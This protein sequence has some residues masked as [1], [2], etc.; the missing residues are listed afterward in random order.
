VGKAGRLD[1]LRP[2]VEGPRRVSMFLT[3]PWLALH[4][5]V[6][7]A[8]VAMVFLG[9]WQLSV[10]NSKHFDLQNFGYALQWWAFSAFA[11][12]F[13]LRTMRDA[14][15]GNT[16]EGASTGG[17]VV[18][19]AGQRGR[20]EGGTYVGP[21]DLVAWD[22]KTGQ[23]P[24]AYRGYLMPQSATSPDHGDGMHGAYND[25]LW[26]LA[27]ADSADPKG[28]IGRSGGPVDEPRP[29]DPGAFQ[30]PGSDTETG[31]LGK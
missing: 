17:Q 20:V 1:R 31:D 30:L 28:H 8:A 3:V 9:R 13:W 18:L 12:F 23:I 22:E 15:R 4:V 7:A 6:W 5:F 29:I 10:S 16:G 27:L 2:P 26:Q 24:V 19:W 21:A 11:V 14:W 25:Y